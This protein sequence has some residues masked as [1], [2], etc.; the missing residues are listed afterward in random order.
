VDASNSPVTNSFPTSISLAIGFYQKSVTERQIISAKVTTDNWE[1]D[2]DN[3]TL[4]LQWQA[5]GWIDLMNTFSFEMDLYVML[6]IICG[7]A[8]LL[9]VVR[10]LLVVIPCCGLCFLSPEKE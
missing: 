6:Y 5:L 1:T 8:Q 9:I 3:Y 7:V 4:S 10:F 2:P